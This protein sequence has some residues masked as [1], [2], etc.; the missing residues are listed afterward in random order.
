MNDHG[1]LP[2]ANVI[3]TMKTE[4]RCRCQ[5]PDCRAE[6]EVRSNSKEAKANPRGCCGA[7]MKKSYSAP[8]F[9]QYGKDPGDLAR[10]FEGSAAQTLEF[11][12]SA[13]QAELGLD[14]G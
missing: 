4:Q 13:S 11:D 6:I 5:N 14:L 1:E 10:L 9:K 12:W 3:R 8:L 7:E 2:E